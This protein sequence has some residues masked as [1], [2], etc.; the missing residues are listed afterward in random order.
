MKCPSVTVLCAVSVM[1]VAMA[2]CDCLRVV[3]MSR[4]SA[5]CVYM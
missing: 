5:L 2:V 1:G 4:L 3:C